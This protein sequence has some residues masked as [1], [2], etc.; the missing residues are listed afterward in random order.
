MENFIRIGPVARELRVSTQTVRRYV[1]DGKL[2]ADMTPGGRYTFQRSYIDEFLGNTPAQTIAYY[3]RASDGDNTRLDTQVSALTQAYGEPV[4]VYRDKSS[5]LN[6]KRPGLSKLIRD[7]RERKFTQIA[8]T[9]KDRLTRFGYHYLELLFHEY[10]VEVLV[11]GEQVEKSLHE[12]LMQDFMSLLASF[13][14]R[15]YRLRGYAQSKRLLAE[16][17][18]RLP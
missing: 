1:K 13:A 17:S 10:G 3:V 18:E 7:A 12:E 5:G 4:R 6:E 14:G 8:I 15:F 16:A 2:R 11:L 9:Q